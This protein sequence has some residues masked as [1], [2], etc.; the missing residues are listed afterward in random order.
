MIDEPTPVVSDSFQQAWAKVVK[1]LAQ[2]DWETRNLMVQIKNTQ[3]FDDGL[4]VRFDGFCRRVEIL[5]PRHVA[6]TIFPHE[7]YA[8]AK[9][10]ERLFR[11]YNR[12]N[13]LYERLQR[14]YRNHSSWGTYF[15]RMTQYDG[16]GKPV[17][18]LENIIKALNTRANVNKAALT[19]VIQRPGGET[20]RPLGGPCLNYLA[21]Q[22]ER[23]GQ[24]TLGLLAVYRNHDFLQKA[25]GNYWGLCNLLGFLANETGTVAGPV[26]CISSHAY[27]EN[28]K[29]A[30]KAFVEAL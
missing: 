9:T 18:Q 27:V 30:L 16:G 1:L 19:I 22:A 17:N 4:H 5:G 28:H 25:Y 2:K 29:L 7:A 12:S 24:T 26:T 3:T 20:I 6:Y 23:D 8:K 10:A 21:V 14:R 11:A 13:G 15:R